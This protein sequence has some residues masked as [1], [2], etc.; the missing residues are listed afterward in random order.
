[1]Y[2]FLFVQISSGFC[3]SAT[4][5]PTAG[6]DVLQSGSQQNMVSSFT[7]LVPEPEL[8]TKVLQFIFYVY[9]ACHLKLIWHSFLLLNLKRF[10]VLVILHACAMCMCSNL[11]VDSLAQI[12]EKCNVRAGSRMLV[13]E[14]CLGLITGS[15]LERMA[16]RLSTGLSCYIAEHYSSLSDCL[17]SKEIPLPPSFLALSGLTR[18]V[19]TLIAF[20]F[21]F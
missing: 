21:C 10:V 19:Y 11:R 18:T 14:S 8:Y 5:S 6:W 4:N 7:S 2:Y 1:M 16:G 15:M 12:L 3:C 13:C 9:I 20:P 17:I